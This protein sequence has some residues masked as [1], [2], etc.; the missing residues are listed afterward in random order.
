MRPLSSSTTAGDSAARS[1]PYCSTTTEWPSA[2][3]EGASVSGHRLR[4]W[5]KHAADDEV[6]VMVGRRHRTATGGGRRH[7]ARRH[8]RWGDLL[9]LVGCERFALFTTTGE[10]WD[11]I[12]VRGLGFVDIV[13]VRISTPTPISDCSGS[14]VRAAG[15]FRARGW[16]TAPARHW[17]SSTSPAHPSTRRRAAPRTSSSLLARLLVRLPSTALRPLR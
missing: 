15:A 6:L 10:S 17:R 9:V 2:D 7:G 3:V 11:Y 8:Q 13:C 12:A 16:T 14:S 1:H 5:R 4:G